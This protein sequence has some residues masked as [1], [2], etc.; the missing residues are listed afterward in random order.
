MA[1]TTT[2]KILQLL[3]PENA[4]ELRC[5]AALV[6]GEIGAKDAAIARALADT[7]RDSDPGVRVQSMRAVGK[8]RVEA[9]LPDLLARVGEGGAEAEVAAQA[10]ARLGAKGT[11]SLRELMNR[12]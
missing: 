12:T 10:A 7:V 2:K 3:Q 1:D 11:K 5:A 6:L 8:L 9:A 4:P